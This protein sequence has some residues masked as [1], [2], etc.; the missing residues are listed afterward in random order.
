M[1]YLRLFGGGVK[2]LLRTASLTS[3]PGMHHP[4]L[5]TQ[6]SVQTPSEES[7]G[8]ANWLN[9]QR[10]KLNTKLL[11]QQTSVMKE[12]KPTYRE[13]FVPPEMSILAFLLQKVIY[14]DILYSYHKFSFFN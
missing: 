9:K 12:D 10:F 4:G 2:K 3:N 13:Q 8:P 14:V 6:T 11:G 1:Y 5:Q 7:S